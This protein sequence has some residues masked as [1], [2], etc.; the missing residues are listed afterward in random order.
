MVRHPSNNQN[1]KRYNGSFTKFRPKFMQ[2]VHK[3]IDFMVLF[4]MFSF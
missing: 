4:I 3:P 1:F 2:F